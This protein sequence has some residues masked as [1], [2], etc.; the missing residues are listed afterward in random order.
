MGHLRDHHSVRPGQESVYTLGE[1]EDE[2]MADD[3]G[4]DIDKLRKAERGKT[5]GDT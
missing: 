1:R 4:E 5:K 2:K 3:K